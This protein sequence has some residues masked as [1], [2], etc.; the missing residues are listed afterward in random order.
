MTT[1]A[2]TD[3]GELSEFGN[4]Y[5]LDELQP[6][7]GLEALDAEAVG[8]LRSVEIVGIER[9][10]IVSRRHHGCSAENEV[11]LSMPVEKA[12]DGATLLEAVWAGYMLSLKATMDAGHAR[13]HI[14]DD[15]DAIDLANAI[16]A[17]LGATATPSAEVYGSDGTFLEML[18]FSH[19]AATATLSVDPVIGS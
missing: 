8:L 7:R 15:E 14:G 6:L 16:V 9:I 11:I 19:D 2:A 17:R 10:E 1:I 12:I 3:A 18:R 4:L 13:A 5:R